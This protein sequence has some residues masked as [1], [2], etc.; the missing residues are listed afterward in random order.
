MRWDEI[1]KD[2][3]RSDIHQQGRE[4]EERRKPVQGP[5]L[6]PSYGIVSHGMTNTLFNR[7]FLRER[8]HSM[9]AP[10][11]PVHLKPIRVA[12]TMVGT[13][14]NRNHGMTYLRL[15]KIATHHQQQVLLPAEPKLAPSSW[16][17]RKI[18]SPPSHPVRIRPRILLLLP[19][20]VCLLLI[21][22]AHGMGGGRATLTG[23]TRDES[24]FI[25]CHH[26]QDRDATRL[27]NIEPDLES[28]AEI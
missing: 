13:K 23:G 10:H 18:G 11:F 4:R 15:H 20:K 6:C 26:G 14:Q 17:R 19:P 8:H 5:G 22:V 16:P 12:K 7:H 9:D 25:F 21:R 1:S 2:S 27:C 24:F 3:P 28:S